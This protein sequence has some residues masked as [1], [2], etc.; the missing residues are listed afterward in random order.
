MKEETLVR[1]AVEL[2]KQ[3][4]VLFDDKSPSFRPKKNPSRF[5]VSIC[6]NTT[7]ISTGHVA[8]DKHFNVLAQYTETSLANYFIRVFNEYNIERQVQEIKVDNS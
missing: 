6:T 4:G 1:Q 5:H 8:I 7:P 2:A 3:K